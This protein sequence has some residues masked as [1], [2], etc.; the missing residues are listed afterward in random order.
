MKKET[1]PIPHTGVYRR[2]G[3]T[4]WQL[5]IKAPS[6]LLHLYPSGWAC[7]VSLDTSDLREANAK[8]KKV[9]DQWSERF[10]EQRREQNPQRADQIT[11][12]FAQVLA[13]RVSARLLASDET[14][15]TDPEV[16]RTLLMALREA[17]PSRLTINRPALPAWAADPIDPLEGLPEDLAEELQQLNANMDQQ[18]AVQAALQRIRTVLPLAQAEARKLGRSF[19]ENTPGAREALR[20]SLKAYR[21]AWQGIRQRDLGEVV[22]TP[23]PAALPNPAAKKARKLRDVFDRWK[24]KTARSRDATQAMERA[25]VQF[26][27]RT[28]NPPLE[29]ITRDMGDD[30]RAWLQTL[31][32]SSKTA[33]DRI[34]AVKTLLK[35]ACDEL[36]WLSR[37]PW[38][39]IDIDHRTENPRHPW[40]A[41]EMKAFFGLPLFQRY[42]LPEITFRNGGDAAYWIPI[43]GLYTGAR[44][45]ELAQLRVQDI[46]STEFGPFISITEEAEGATVKTAAGIRQV[47]VHPELVRLGFMEYVEAMQKAGNAA[48]WPAYKLRKG[49]PGGYFSDWVNPFHKEATGNPKAPVFHELRHTVRTALHRA[50]I[51]PHTI[52]L[53]V[54]HKNGALTKVQ[55]G[56]T[57][58]H[59]EDLVAAIRTLN[60]PVKLPKVYP[61]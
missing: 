32:L 61:G 20:E 35:Y 10:K 16:A 24:A 1:M 30:F 5:R 53:I 25:L 2:P 54:G 46:Q 36:E 60:F 17:V 19:D 9:W 58:M 22:E 50:R 57:H 43:L 4:R 7:R 13:Q 6:D 51:D 8:A 37:Q 33:H 26:E 52:D 40:T 11:P 39:G 21:K 42:E 3:S 38:K 59:E 34:T 29:A 31:D 56:Y 47:P 28:G 23:A 45:G 49:K 15:R 41:D 55:K 12:E 18:A 14:L 48:L 44:V 27:E